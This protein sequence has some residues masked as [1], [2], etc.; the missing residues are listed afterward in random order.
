M[1][2]VIMIAS[3]SMV[4][5]RPWGGA[6]APGAREVIVIGRRERERRSSGFSLTVPLG[7]GAAEITTRRHSTEAVGGAPMGRWFWEQGGEI[8]AG[9][10]AMDNR[11]ALV[12]TFIGR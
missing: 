5:S 2:H 12:M 8:G 6:A 1:D 11:G 3:R 7:G 10:G 9:V 4:D